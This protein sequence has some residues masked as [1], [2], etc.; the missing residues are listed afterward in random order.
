MTESMYWD[1][2]REG[3]REDSDPF[4]AQAKKTHTQMKSHPTGR[5]QQYHVVIPEFEIQMQNV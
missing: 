1:G 2:L 3:Q 4:T 5:W